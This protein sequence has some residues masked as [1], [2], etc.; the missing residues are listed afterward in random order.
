MHL[1]Y[2]NHFTLNAETAIALFLL[3]V[4]C[5]ASFSDVFS[6]IEVLSVFCS[7]A[8]TCKNVTKTHESDEQM[9]KPSCFHPAFAKTLISSSYIL[10]YLFITFLS[11]ICFLCPKSFFTLVICYILFLSLTCP[12]SPSL[13]SSG[14]T[15]PLSPPMSLSTLMKSGMIMNTPIIMKELRVSLP[16]NPSLPP[17][18]PGPSPNR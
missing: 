7:N 14:F 8:V 3:T 12:L 9:I 1:F 10:L 15:P 4:Y 17:S 18:Q 2:N 6:F 13:H 11:S 5:Y 16:P